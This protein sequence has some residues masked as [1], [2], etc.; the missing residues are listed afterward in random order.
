MFKQTVL[1]FVT[2][3]GM[4]KQCLMIVYNNSLG[5]TVFCLRRSNSD[6]GCICYSVRSE[7]RKLQYCMSEMNSW[8]VR[9]I[10]IITLNKIDLQKIKQA[11]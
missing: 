5:G 1:T 8:I 7:Y 6:F 4:A 10:F 3:G 9:V 2:K 11:N